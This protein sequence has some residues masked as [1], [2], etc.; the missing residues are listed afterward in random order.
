MKETKKNNFFLRIILIVFVVFIGLN[1]SA[2]NYY[3]ND[4][5]NEVVLT[6]EN[7]ALFEQDIKD[8]KPLDLKKYQSIDNHDYG[9][10]FSNT[11]NFVGKRLDFVM[12]NGIDEGIKVLKKLFSN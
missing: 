4:L 12:L 10:L 3:A 9:N 7:M 8:G 2:D 6:E 5:H 1:I 11:G